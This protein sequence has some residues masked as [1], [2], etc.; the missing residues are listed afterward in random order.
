[1]LLTFSQDS[2]V[3][4]IKRGTKIHT[5]REDKKC[6]WKVGMKIHFWRGNPRNNK[7][8]NKPYPF[9]IPGEEPVVKR[10]DDIR[11]YLEPDNYLLIDVN[12]RTLGPYAHD[13]LI[14]NDGFY[15]NTS[16]KKWFLPD[17]KREFTG[18]LIHWTDF[19][20]KTL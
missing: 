3:D 15:G 17:G 6:R 1:M 2:F 13:S 9:M 18:R 12:G 16:F 10:I 5:I 19:E 20:Y 14:M 4:A 7:G 8:V 11:I